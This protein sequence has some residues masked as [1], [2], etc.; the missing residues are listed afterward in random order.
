MSLGV[1]AA[2]DKFYDY[3]VIGRADHLPLSFTSGKCEQKGV[4]GYEG[5]RRLVLDGLIVKITG[6][7]VVHI[8]LTGSLDLFNVYR[9]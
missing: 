6:R 9:D 5:R 1:S 4:E 7:I 3:K 8:M 2:G